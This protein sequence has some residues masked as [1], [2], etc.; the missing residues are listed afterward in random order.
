MN[1]RTRFRWRTDGGVRLLEC[2]ALARVARHG[3]TTRALA[4]GR[5]D[6]D[7]T[8]WT[9]L[10]AA[11]D[12]PASAVVRLRQVHGTTV[13]RAPVPQPAEGR[14]PCGD[15]LV[16]TDPSVALVVQ[17]ADCVPL[18]L[19]DRRSGAVA[20]VHAGWR[21]TAARAAVAAIDALEAAGARAADLVVALGPSIGPCCYQV[22][23]EVRD[24]FVAAGHHPGDLLR[25]FGPDEGD[26]LRLDLWQA[27]VDALVERGVPPSAVHVAG[28]CTAHDPHTFFSYRRE[29]AS[30]GRLAGVIRAASGS[31]PRPDTASG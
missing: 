7:A 15:A 28:L 14:P 18:L 20:A 5:P 2:L 24:G 1:D 22:G 23:T 9:R 17:A 16:T 30:T 31:S 12:L 3:F 26:R 11:F 8:A 4:L 29:G 27:N 19:A 6:G 25:W 10:A 21:G 13:V